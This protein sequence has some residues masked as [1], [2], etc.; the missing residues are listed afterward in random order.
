MLVTKNKNAIFILKIAFLLLI[1]GC[2]YYFSGSHSSENAK[3]IEVK[4]DYLVIQSNAS[5]GGKIK[6]L[7]ISSKS[8]IPPLVV[9]KEYYFVSDQRY[10]QRPYIRFVED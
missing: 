1:I 2:I 3:L 6:K 8:V 5:N 10:F 9:G 4:D 7:Y